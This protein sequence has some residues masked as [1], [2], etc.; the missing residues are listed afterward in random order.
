MTGLVVLG[1]NTKVAQ[2]AATLPVDLIHVQHPGASDAP[3]L[4]NGAATVFTVDY[5]EP[6][7]FTTFIDEVL[8]PLSPLA[9]VSLTEPGLE[10]AAAATERL[11]TPGTALSV[12]QAIR[13][14]LIMRR[15]LAHKAP[16]LNPAFAAGDDPDA[17]A[18]LFAEH[19]PV[20]AKP[21][22]GSGSS[23]VALIHR[24]ADL[25]PHRRT[26]ATLLEQFVGGLEVS[27]ESLSAGGRHTTMGI[28][29][30]GTTTGF[31]ELSH[32]MPAPSLT[33]RQRQ[34]VER[35]VAEVLD[36]LGLTDG[37]SHTELK[38]DGDQVTV[39]ETHNRMGGD[40][41]AD[42][43]Q[44]TTGV[45]WRR[46]ALG[47]AVGGGAPRTAAIAP[48]AATVFFTA[49]P[50]QVTAVASQPT[51]AHGSIVDWAISAQVGE[52]VKPLQSSLER[53]GFAVLTADS[54][55]QCALAVAELTA[56]PIVTT[57]PAR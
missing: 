33:E 23:E 40:G 35:A 12:V 24:P 18:R 5:R 38:I 20:I 57:Q 39:I 50:G 7:T 43:V 30:K 16:H 17:I 10:P 4:E 21:V 1:A 2:A 37:P 29:Q 9:V 49:P 53:L 8:A 42:L 22:D 26:A 6:A 56:L 19:T 25:P 36:A 45:D 54:A 3:E 13:N 28:A 31:V 34:L 27:V 41:I 52:T 32:V 48:A 47:W 44:L 11:G 15:V 14:K 46:S 51:L 55:E